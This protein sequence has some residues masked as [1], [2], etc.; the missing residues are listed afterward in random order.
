LGF[1]PKPKG[2]HFSVVGIGLLP[3]TA[4]AAYLAIRFWWF[5]GTWV[6]FA[7]LLLANAALFARWR[8]APKR[9]GFWARLARSNRLLPRKLHLTMEGRFLLLITFGMGFAAVNTGNNLFY[10]ILGLLLSLIVL[11]GMMSEQV[12]RGLSHRAFY[13]SRAVAG[14]PAVLRV[15]VTN[16]LRRFHAWSIVLD[17]VIDDPEVSH[18]PGRIPVLPPRATGPGF[19]E[20]VF[21]RRGRYLSAGFLLSTTYPFSFFLK[22][23]FFPVPTAF[24]VHPRSDLV[25]DESLASFLGGSGETPA[26]GRGRGGEFHSARPMAPGDDPRD[27]HWKRSAAYG[28]PVIREFDRAIHRGVTLALWP[29]LPPSATAQ[30]EGTVEYAVDYAASVLVWLMSHGIKAGLALPGVSLAA[31]LGPA[32]EET[33]LDAL[34]VA[35]VAVAGSA[36]SVRGLDG[37]ALSPLDGSS[38]VFLRLPWQVAP[39]V[40]SVLDLPP[41]PSNPGPRAVPGRGF[42]PG[43]QP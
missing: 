19:L 25:P 37:Q 13:P 29:E 23:R 16:P 3:F 21:P 6:M 35:P 30:D 22:S 18:R 38:L 9:P 40:D 32:Q 17:E 27:I 1:L 42:G 34:A 2:F 14:R 4:S 31:G 10:L 28:A 39:A 26:P 12:L 11:S 20:L 41:A 7:I 43:V 24:L 8:D 36:Y 5:K 15:E 33:L